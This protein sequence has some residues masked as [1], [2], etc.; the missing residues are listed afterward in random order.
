MSYGNQVAKIKS[1]NALNQAEETTYFGLLAEAQLS[2]S[3][4][5]AFWKLI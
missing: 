3:D 2:P 5:H 1:I 4:V